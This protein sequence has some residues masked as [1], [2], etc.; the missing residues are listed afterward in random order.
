MACVPCVKHVDFKVVQVVLSSR[1]GQWRQPDMTY[2]IMCRWRRLTN[3]VKFQNE[4]GYFMGP[5]HW[6]VHCRAS[7]QL[8]C[9]D[10]RPKIPVA[11][12]ARDSAASCVAASRGQ[13]ARHP[14]ARGGIA[15]EPTHQ[16]AAA[17][18]L[19][20]GCNSATCASARRIWR[21]SLRRSAWRCLLRLPADT[22]K[23]DAATASTALL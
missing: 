16:R 9:P 23:T 19:Q 1:S 20:G 6:Q 12:H 2:C 8:S 17:W 21:A 3:F 5:S 10:M 4:Q 11:Q 13:H 15:A 22:H 7:H 18:S 14:H